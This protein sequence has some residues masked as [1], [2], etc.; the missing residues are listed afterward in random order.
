MRT[1][2]A[3]A[4]ALALGACREADAP[5]PPA[6]AGEVSFRLDGEPWSDRDDVAAWVTES[7]GLSLTAQGDCLSGSRCTAFS[8]ELGDLATGSSSAAY[9][10]TGPAGVEG[11][12]ITESLVGDSA[13]AWTFSHLA[14]G[15]TVTVE[16]AGGAGA[17]VA[18]TFEG[19]FVIQ[20]HQRSA[21]G[22]TLPDTLRVTDGAFRVRP[23]GA[24]GPP[25]RPESD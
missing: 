18:G 5:E 8:L 24:N 11:A 13:A 19:V 12:V 9:R 7:G 14:T 20:D 17:L 22:R 10:D 25:R 1:P 6:S 15:G 16:R 2:A 3:L 23:W 21:P 4:L